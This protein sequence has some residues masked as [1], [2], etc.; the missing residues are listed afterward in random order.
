MIRNR[1]KAL[2]FVPGPKLLEAYKTIM[3][4]F[5]DFV[6]LAGYKMPG[7]E[8]ELLHFIGILGDEYF[9]VLKGG[10]KNETN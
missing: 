6:E 9:K 3:E 10:N 8:E 1:F 2:T 5:Q 7:T 4:S